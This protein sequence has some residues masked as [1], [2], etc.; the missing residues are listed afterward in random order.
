MSDLRT[1]FSKQDRINELEA[2]L[3]RVKAELTKVRK[4]AARYKSDNKAL[5][6]VKNP[7]N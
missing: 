7:T 4:R 5:K 6:E 3:R 2:E 1:Y